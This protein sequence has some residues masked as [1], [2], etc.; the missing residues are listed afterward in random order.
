MKKLIGLLSLTAALLHSLVQAAPLRIGIV[1]MDKVYREYNKTKANEEELEK[2]K[3]S[4]RSE[5][6]KRV[7][8]LTSL[9]EEGKK[10]VSSAKAL[11]EGSPAHK[12]AIEELNSKQAE[13]VSLQ[14]DTME[15]QEKRRRMI[16]D[17]LKRFRDDIM[18]DLHAHVEKVA[19][20]EKYDLVFDKTGISSSGVEVLIF[21]KD[22]ID[23]TDIV[24]K[25]LNE[26][27]PGPAPA[28]KPE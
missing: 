22:A 3:A 18:I 4:A 17:K 19:A 26:G 11:T 1:D 27:V 14:R 24:L 5:I 23:F 9:N 13:L 7:S 15:F 12:K 8:K 16:L 20:S 25:G 6:E 28:T 10:M 2:D 21:S